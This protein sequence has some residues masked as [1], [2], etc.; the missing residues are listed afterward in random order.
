MPRRYDDDPR[1][2]DKGFRERTKDE[3]DPRDREKKSWREI[4]QQRD[5]SE[6][7]RGGSPKGERL[8]RAESQSYR[9]YK[10]QLD[11]LF[12]GG[13]VPDA[14]KQRMEEAGIG[15]DKKARAAA[16]KT[17]IGA[18]KQADKLEALNVYREAHGFPVEEEVLAVL[19]DL[20]DEPDVVREAL[21]TIEARLDEGQLK[22]AGSL[23]ARIKTAKM[24]V[25]DDDVVEVAGRVLG[26]L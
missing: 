10:S 23:K 20:D 12:D 16:A 19:L 6:H 1:N 25:D 26:K 7:R 13:G 5:K 4:D 21:E 15:K 3:P 9:A 24:T 17:I 14:L 11:K 18:A 8:P 2:L 22:R